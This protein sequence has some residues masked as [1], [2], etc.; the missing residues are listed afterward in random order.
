M[1]ILKIDGKK[2]KKLFPTASP[3]FQEMLKDTF[4]EIFFSQK[5]TDRIKTFE[6]ACAHLSLD[7]EEYLPF[8]IPKNARKQASN[9]FTMLDIISEAL[10]DGVKLDWTNSDQKKW[11]PWFNEYSPGS[12]FRFGGTGYAWTTSA[13]GGG[14]RLCLDTEEKARYFGTQFID[15]WNQYLNPNK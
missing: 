4:G 13:T 10:L 5:I 15:I 12:G 2:A 1:E 8:L 9:A 6:D 14:A 7:P 11:Y 3:E